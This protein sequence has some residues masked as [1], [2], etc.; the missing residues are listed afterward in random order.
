MEASIFSAGSN[1][2]RASS[3]GLE[4]TICSMRSMAPISDSP[5]FTSDSYCLREIKWG[6]R[7]GQINRP[8]AESLADSMRWCKAS[9]HA[10]SWYG[11]LSNSLLYLATASSNCDISELK[12]CSIIE[13]P[14]QVRKT[15]GSDAQEPA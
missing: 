10:K 11:P 14:T 13:Y 4:S 3:D 1:S 15:I 9:A 8:P 12:T 5:V 7:N 2:R 6:R